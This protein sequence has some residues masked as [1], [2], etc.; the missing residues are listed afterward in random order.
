MGRRFRTSYIFDS[1]PIWAK[2]SIEFLR[3][4]MSKIDL[5]WK[6]GQI[7]GMVFLWVAY[8]EYHIRFV[9]RHEGD[10]QIGKI[11][12]ALEIERSIDSRVY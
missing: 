1:T 7:I 9:F 11:A 3:P 12:S 6:M 4:K 5:P 2:K 8:F 10:N